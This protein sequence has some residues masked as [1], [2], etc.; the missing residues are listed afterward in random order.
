MF[1]CDMLQSCIP[2]PSKQATKMVQVLR[3]WVNH[4]FY[5]YTRG[6]HRSWQLKFQDLDF[7]CWSI[8]MMSV[9]DSQKQK[10]LIVFIIFPSGFQHSCLVGGWATPLNNMKVNWDDDSQCEN[11]TWQPNHQPVYLYCI[12]WYLVYGIIMYYLKSNAILKQYIYTYIYIRHTIIGIIVIFHI[13]DVSCVVA[14]PTAQRQ[15]GSDAQ[16]YVVLVLPEPSKGWKPS[17]HWPNHRPYM[18]I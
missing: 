14:V 10:T 6:V 2:R 4:L 11:K 1:T 16:R 17:A 3:F 9:Q 13:P 12:C 8:P 18:E 5:G 7:R 15:Q